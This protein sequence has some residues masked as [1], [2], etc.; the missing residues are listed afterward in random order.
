MIELPDENKQVVEIIL[1]PSHKDGEPVEVIQRYND[2]S[3]ET[4]KYMNLLLSLN[5]DEKTMG[6]AQG[7]SEGLAHNVLSAV[8]RAVGDKPGV[9]RRALG[10]VLSGLSEALMNSEATTFWEL[11]SEISEH[12]RAGILKKIQNLPKELAELLQNI[13]D[14]LKNDGS[15]K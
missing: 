12:L 9:Q 11:E 8:V 10:F 5:S 4:D 13:I 6:A 1:K 7:S 3:T 14:N 15:S 2:N